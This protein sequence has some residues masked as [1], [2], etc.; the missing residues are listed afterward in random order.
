MAVITITEKNFVANTST[1]IVLLDFWAAWCGPCR[2]FAPVF[3]AAALRHPD[4]TF[5]KVDVDG[6]ATR[7]HA[8]K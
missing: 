8:G 3:E 2:G 5:G 7:C 4:I 6:G 1:G